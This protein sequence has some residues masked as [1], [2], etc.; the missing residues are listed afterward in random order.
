MQKNGIV[1]RIIEI[2]LDNGYTISGLETACN[3]TRGILLMSKKRGSDIGT[4]NLELFVKSLPKIAKGRKVNYEYLLLGKTPKYLN[5]YRFAD[6]Q[7]YVR[8]P[9]IQDDFEERLEVALDNENIQ[10][11][12]R[13]IINVAQ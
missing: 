11:K 3:M 7:P 2:G 4:A 13:E 9:G 8:E 12:L 6:E 5:T 1:K 10:Q